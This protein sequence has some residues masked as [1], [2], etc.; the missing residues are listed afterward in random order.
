[1]P[2]ISVDINSYPYIFYFV[3]RGSYVVGASLILTKE[4]FNNICFKLQKSFALV[5]V[6]FERCKQFGAFTAL[7]L[8]G[9]AMQNLIVIISPP[10]ALFFRKISF[11]HVYIPF[12]DLI[13]KIII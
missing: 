5:D 9:G 12:I 4:L 7:S 13:K 6:L 11:S 10:L 2:I 1:M 8:S 3:C